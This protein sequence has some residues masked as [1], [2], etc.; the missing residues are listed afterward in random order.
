MFQLE[1]AI[2]RPSLKAIRNNNYV[3]YDSEIKEKS[4]QSTHC[5]HTPLSNESD[6][7]IL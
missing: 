2:I 1:G 6:N 4:Y 7:N 5:I 3:K